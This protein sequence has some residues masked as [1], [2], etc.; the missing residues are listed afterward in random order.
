[1]TENNH[2]MY[3]IAVIP[4]DGIGPEVIE[5][6]MLVANAA[7][8][9]YGV[10]VDWHEY[11][12]GCAYYLKHGAMLE[13]GGL[14]A[15]KDFDAIY[16]GAVGYPTVPDHISLRQ[17]LLPIRMHY[18]LAINLRPIRLLPGLE[19]PVK[20]V[21]DIDFVI[22][23]ENTEGEYAGAGGR[24]HQ[25]TGD[26][27]AVQTGIFTYHG[28]RR[29]LRYAFRLAESR[30]KRLDIITKSNALQYSMVFWDEQA[31]ELHREFPD[32][33]MR[34]LHIDAA[35]ARMMLKPHE[36]D[37]VVA[38]NLFGDILSDLGAA[39]IGGLGIAPSANIHADNQKPAL[40][41]PVHG[42]APDIE[43]AGL[44]N[45]VAA[46]WTAAMMFDWLGENKVGQA[47]MK[48]L[49]ETLAEGITTRDLG[50]SSRT[51]DVAAA[52]MNRLA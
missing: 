49:G 52:V 45:P 1:M 16:L 30:R 15:L 22:V 33:T 40:F 43:D 46:I 25:G 37:V 14:E 26:E 4:G 2:H 44:A 7:T 23:R 19:C 48:A 36:F 32:V 13:D 31:R 50:G 8:N 21:D 18:D 10:A 3:R 28:V 9:L 38:S 39:L 47:I 34:F 6:G 24:T 42:S 20:G 27:V 12:W 29:V 51:M 41:E 11:P 5:A 35:A 17:L